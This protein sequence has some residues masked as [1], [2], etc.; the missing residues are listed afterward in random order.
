MQNQ[1]FPDIPSTFPTWV[2]Y[3]TLA[4]YCDQLSIAKKRQ[5][6]LLIRSDP[7]LQGEMKQVS[8]CHNHYM[9]LLGLTMGEFAVF[10]TIQDFIRKN[11]NASKKRKKS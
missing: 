10:H 3:T 9:P 2:K 4:S 5:V 7:N 6:F 1:R 11:S 8:H